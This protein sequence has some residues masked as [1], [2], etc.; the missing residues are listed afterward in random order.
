MTLISSIVHFGPNSQTKGLMVE[1]TNK[2]NGYGINGVSKFMPR[3]GAYFYNGIGNPFILWA[4]GIDR[5]I[6]H[7]V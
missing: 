2:S 6:P 3:P 1:A 4:S 5:L 7:P